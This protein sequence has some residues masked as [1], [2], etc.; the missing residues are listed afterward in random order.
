MTKEERREGLSFHFLFAF[1]VLLWVAH[2]LRGELGPPL[3]NKF[4]NVPLG[5]LR[6]PLTVENAQDLHFL[7]VFQVWQELWGDQEVLRGIGF[8]GGVHND[9][10]HLALVDGVHALVDLINHSERAACHVL[11][12]HQVQ[13][14]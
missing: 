12:R 9:R 3:G 10:V 4:V 6:L 8:R 11:K 5:V 1:F 7:V 13:N 14:G 2:S